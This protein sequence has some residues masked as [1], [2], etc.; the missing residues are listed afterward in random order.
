MLVDLHGGAGFAAL[1][2]SV[3]EAVAAGRRPGLLLTSE[4]LERMR[5]RFRGLV[6]SDLGSEYDAATVASRLFAAMRDL[7]RD[8][9][10][11]CLIA[12]VMPPEGLGAAV[13]DRLRRAANDVTDGQE[14]AGSSR[15]L[16]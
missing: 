14:P 1:E 2:N 3:A 4:D 8:P 7:D 13:N 6:T 10:T 11:D 15:T 9:R 12:R 5:E 16:P